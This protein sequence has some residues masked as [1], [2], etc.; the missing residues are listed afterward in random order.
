MAKENGL[1]HASLFTRETIKVLRI[2]HIL[3]V[4]EAEDGEKPF[5][6]LIACRRKS[7]CISVPI[8]GKNAGSKLDLLG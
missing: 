4:P 2:I 8:I 1:A 6:Q 5:F 7:R 3:W